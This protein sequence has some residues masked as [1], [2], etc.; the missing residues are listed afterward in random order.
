MRN[1]FH[2]FIFFL[3]NCS[4]LFCIYLSTHIYIY[5]FTYSFILS[6]FRLASISISFPI[7]W[8]ALYWFPIGWLAL[9]WFSHYG[10]IIDP[11]AIPEPHTEP[12][13]YSPRSCL[14]IRNTKDVIACC[15]AGRLQGTIVLYK[16][17]S[18]TQFC[19]WVIL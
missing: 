19:V 10:S 16:Y 14:H 12:L 11:H 13:G 9:Y 3:F 18:F 15:V 4:L 5:L 2:Q 8:L 7:G 6:F 17:S 1:K